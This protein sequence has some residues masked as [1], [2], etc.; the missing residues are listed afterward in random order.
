M[1]DLSPA[2]QAIVNAWVENTQYAPIDDEP[3]ALAAAIRVIADQVVPK[4][5]GPRN[6]LEY[7]LGDWDARDDVRNKLLDIATEL[8]SPS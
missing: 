1:T 6:Q 4:T 7:E 3:F 5:K 8:E 2:A